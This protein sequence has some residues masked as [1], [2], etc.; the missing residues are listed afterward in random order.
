MAEQP[1]IPVQT[2]KLPAPRDLLPKETR[3]SLTTWLYTAQNW[4]ARDDGFNHFVLPGTTWNHNEQHYGFVAEPATS[5]LRRTAPEMEAAFHRFTAALS[6]F[7][8][9]G[10]LAR[11]FPLTTNW[12]GI[13]DLVYRAYNKQL[14][15]ASLLDHG[16]LKKQDD[17]EQ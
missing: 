14:N 12:Q 17:E 5:K 4:L 11:R 16:S 15:A 7:F 13:K 9:F 1:V 10:F 3:E 2:C 8:P 6:G